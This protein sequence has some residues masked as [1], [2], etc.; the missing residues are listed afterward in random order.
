[1]PFLL[2]CGMEISCLAYFFIVGKIVD[3]VLLRKLA[4]TTFSYFGLLIGAFTFTVGFNI[5]IDDLFQV[6]NGNY[7]ISL[8]GFAFLL[9]FWFGVVKLGEL[10]AIIFRSRK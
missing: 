1:M 5:F 7:M 3:S 10:T 6:R 4:T 8:I 2:I 9:G